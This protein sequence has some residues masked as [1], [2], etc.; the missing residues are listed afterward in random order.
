MAD[1]TEGY[2]KA[3]D[4]IKAVQSYKDAKKQYNDAKKKAGDSIEKSKAKVTGQLDKLSGN[5]DKKLDKASNSLNGAQSKIENYQ[6]QLKTQLDHLLDLSNTIGGSSGSS[7]SQTKYIK[8]LFITAIKN[9]EPKIK[10]IVIDECINAVGCDRQQTYT[11]GT[12]YIKVQ[13]IDVLSILKKDPTSKLGSLSYEKNIDI[14]NQNQFSPYSMNRQLYDNIQTGQSYY[15]TYGRNYVGQS[16]QDLLDIQ[17]VDVNPNNGDNSGWY[18]V[19]LKARNNL[20]VGEFIGDYYKTIKVVETQ[21]IMSG[22]MDSLCGAV[23]IKAN[24]GLGQVEDQTRAE[25]IIQRILGLCFENKSEIDVSGI[26]K[27]SEQNGALDNSFF[28]FTEI[29]LRNIDL[30]VTNIQNGVTQFEECDNIKLPVNADAI[31]DELANLIHVSDNNLVQSCDNLTTTLANN[32]DWGIGVQANAQVAVDTNFIKLITQG[33]VGSVISPKV[34]LPIYAMLKSLGNDAIDKIDSFMSFLKNFRTFAK[35]VVSKIGA[36]FIKEL[37]DLIKKDILLLV[38]DVIVDLVKEKAKKRLSMILKLIALIL[39]VAQLIKDWRECKSVLDEILALLDLIT[40][41]LPGFGN[42]IPLPLLFASQMLDGYSETRAFIGAI[43]EMQS[44]GIPT[45][46]MPSGAPNLELL[47]K[48]GQMKSM[49]SEDNDN[50]QIQLAV[51]PLK[52]SPVGVTIPDK[53]YGKKL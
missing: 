12:V 50:N 21:N 29:D 48:F 27:L 20:K 44:A 4:R 1:L 51:P 19:D 31:V 17:Y 5:V 7:G 32:P 46:S 3:S 18:K 23:S 11:P 9:V 45:G 28:E 37:F 25:I 10:Q 16:G 8:R 33:I 36:L 42:D 53:A 43:E 26:A 22:I 35:N 39:I 34:L 38:Q 2:N 47:S 24:A 30:R 41:G 15:Q 14:A 6:K 13:S 52:M 40:S 49:A